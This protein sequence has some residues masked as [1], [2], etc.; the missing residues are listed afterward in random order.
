MG[1]DFIGT[2]TDTRSAGEIAGGATVR[3]TPRF[4][5]QADL[6]YRRTSLF[7]QRLRRVALELAATWRF[8]AN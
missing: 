1:V 3:V 6:G 5:V 7:N 2:T 4:G 8:G